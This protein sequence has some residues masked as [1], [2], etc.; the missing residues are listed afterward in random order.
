MRQILRQI[1]A[2]LALVGLSMN[3]V[4]SALAVTSYTDVSAANKLANA[5]IIVNY[6]A[7]PAGYHLNAVD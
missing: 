1:V 5:G 6:S 4:P 7:N 2:V 3:L